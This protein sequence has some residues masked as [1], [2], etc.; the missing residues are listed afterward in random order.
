MWMHTQFD[1]EEIRLCKIPKSLIEKAIRRDMTPSE[2]YGTGANLIRTKRDCRLARIPA[3]CGIIIRA[4]P[5][6][7]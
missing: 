5:S 7:F 6:A 4:L 1:R 3:A 2:T